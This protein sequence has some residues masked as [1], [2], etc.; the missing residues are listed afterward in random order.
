MK[1]LLCRTLSILKQDGDVY[2]HLLKI[3]ASFKTNTGK[4]CVMPEDV[5]LHRATG[6]QLQTARTPS[7]NISHR[8]SFSTRI[9]HLAR[10]H[11]LV[12]HLTALTSGRENQ[13]TKLT[14]PDKF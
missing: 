1:K 2:R 9:P 7:C 6:V 14:S 4:D 8:S 3:Q 12:P 10:P 5:V 13:G 11:S